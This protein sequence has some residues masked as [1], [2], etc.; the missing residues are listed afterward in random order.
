MC[1]DK[2]L[3][4]CDKVQTFTTLRRRISEDQHGSSKSNS[5]LKKN[6]HDSRTMGKNEQKDLVLKLFCLFFSPWKPFKLWYFRENCC[7]FWL[8]SVRGLLDRYTSRTTRRKYLTTRCVMRWTL[9]IYLQLQ[10][11]KN[12]KN[13]I[14]HQ[15]KFD[16]NS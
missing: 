10:T 8:V 4:F 3:K 13:L 16:K 15:T 11:K 12:F 7:N 14:A 2:V 9:E 1:C 6:H 5:K